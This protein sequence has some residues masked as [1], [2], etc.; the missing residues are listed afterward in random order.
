[1]LKKK[2]DKKSYLGLLC[3]LVG[4]RET[5]KKKQGLVK[6]KKKEVSQS[7][8]QAEKGTGGNGRKKMK[9]TFLSRFKFSL[10]S[11]FFFS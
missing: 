2:E 8:S 4:E 10:N 11:L 3:S 7:V 5:E 6:Q 1:M 9:S